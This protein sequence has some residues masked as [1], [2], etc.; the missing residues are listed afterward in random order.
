MAYAN[1]I[2]LVLYAGA[3]I[4]S[5][6]LHEIAHGWVARRCGDPTAEAAGRLSLNPIRHVDPFMTIILPILVLFSSGGRMIFGGAKPVPVNPYNFRNLEIDDLKVSV[7]GVITNMAI[8]LICGFAL[9]LWQPGTVGFTL[10]TMITVANLGLAFFN[11]IPIPPLDGSHV[12]RFFLAKVSPPL[13]D[14]YQRLGI[15][16]LIFIFLLAGYFFAPIRWAMDFFWFTVLGH[17]TVDW[18][19]V[20]YDFWQ[21]F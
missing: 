6:V 10:F 15:V 2:V 12:A 16:G 5:I 11:L 17:N 14:A 13:A 20:I 18:A 4:M 1:Y 19:R 21:T 8:A 7:A 9:H 3:L